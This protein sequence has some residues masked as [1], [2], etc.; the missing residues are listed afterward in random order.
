MKKRKLEKALKRIGK[1]NEYQKW[2]K[3][4]KEAER[5]KEAFN[6]TNDINEILK[7]EAHEK[8]RN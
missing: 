2:L 5:Q 1:S 6:K 3:L 8:T 7:K 4:T